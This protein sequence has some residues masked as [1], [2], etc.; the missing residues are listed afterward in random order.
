MTRDDTQHMLAITQR[1]F[2][3][4]CLFVALLPSRILMCWNKCGLS[5]GQFLPKLLYHNKHWA[6]CCIASAVGVSLP[7]GSGTLMAVAVSDRPR[8]T[9][10]RTVGS[11]GGL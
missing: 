11:L 1:M 5:V 9:V 3:H 7:V 8:R 4:K 10:W 6:G 2:R